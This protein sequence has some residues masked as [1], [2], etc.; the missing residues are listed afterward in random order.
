MNIGSKLSVYNAQ[1]GA[2]IATDIAEE[3]AQNRKGLLGFMQRKLIPA[4]MGATAGYETGKTMQPIRENL[5]VRRQARKFFDNNAALQKKHGGSFR[6]FYQSEIKNPALSSFDRAGKTGNVTGNPA[7]MPEGFQE[8]IMTGSER[9][10]QQLSDKA[11]IKAFYLTGVKNYY[12]PKPDKVNEKTGA[13]DVVQTNPGV[14]VNTHQ[15]FSDFMD[16]YRGGLFERQTMKQQAYGG[17]TV[18]MNFNTDFDNKFVE[19]DLSKYQVQPFNLLNLYR[20]N[21]LTGRSDDPVVTVEGDT[22]YRD[23]YSYTDHSTMYDEFPSDRKLKENIKKIGKSMSGLG[24]YTFNYIGQAKK[25]IGTMADEV[26]KIK[27]EAVTI[28]DGFMA[29]RY[30]LIDVNFEEI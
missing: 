19:T 16:K 8:V 5:Q 10:A 3:E 24:I 4:I 2:E 6:R 17:A 25:Y 22:V 9:S 13:V 29:V 1:A 27:P 26:L 7:D 21:Q 14:N 20:Q 28:R 11:T 18:D 23:D 15:Q 30:D 12:A